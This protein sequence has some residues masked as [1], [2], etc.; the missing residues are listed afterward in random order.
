MVLVLLRVSVDGPAR[1]VW[2]VSHDRDAAWMADRC[3]DVKDGRVLR[4][5]GPSTPGGSL[6]A[7]EEAR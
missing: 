5:L 4:G 1:S 2:M 7:R 6:E 3:V